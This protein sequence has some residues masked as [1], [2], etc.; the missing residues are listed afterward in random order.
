MKKYFRLPNELFFFF[1]VHRVKLTR[2][3]CIRLQ[4]FGEMPFPRLHAKIH[5]KSL[6]HTA[7]S[8]SNC[9]PT[10]FAYI[11]ICI[12][13]CFIIRRL[14]KFQI[15]A[16]ARDLDRS[17]CLL[18]EFGLDTNRLCV[19]TARPFK[20][21]TENFLHR[22]VSFFISFFSVFAMSHSLQVCTSFR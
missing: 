15:A 1:F 16:E 3:F 7:C 14:G 18:C 2:S 21:C 8:S 4:R 9:S 5:R 10:P 11:I 22:A 12:G 6:R 17:Q 20:Y 19:S 13:R